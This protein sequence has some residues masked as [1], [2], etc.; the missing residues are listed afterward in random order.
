MAT[1]PGADRRGVAVSLPTELASFVTEEI[2]VRA[3][4][5]PES[6]IYG[7]S[8]TEVDSAPVLR[9]R[10]SPGG[11]PPLLLNVDGG[12]K[13]FLC[14]CPEFQKR[15]GYPERMGIRLCEHLTRL[16]TIIPAHDR[17]RIRLESGWRTLRTT[18]ELER[19]EIVT[20]AET[21]LEQGD[22]LAAINEVHYGIRG[23]RLSD[24]DVSAIL[25]GVN[26]DRIDDEDL[27]EA[28]RF[29]RVALQRGFT[30]TTRALA[31]SWLMRFTENVDH[32][33]PFIDVAPVANWLHRR[34]QAP[35]V[36]F[37]ELREKILEA[38]KRAEEK[39]RGASWWLLFRSVSRSAAKPPESCVIAWTQAIEQ[40]KLALVH[41]DR[42]N[43]AARLVTRF[44]TKVEISDKA[45][46][47]AHNA[48]VKRARERR[49]HY[50]LRLIEAHRLA[51]FLTVEESSGYSGGP[52]SIEAPKIKS[53]LE[54]FLLSA[55]GH[56]GKTIPAEDFA[57]NWPVIRRLSIVEPDIDGPVGDLARSIWP[58]KVE[59]PPPV[60]KSVRPGRI[61]VG[62][63][64]AFISRW[65]LSAPRLIANSPVVAH[66]GDRIY[67]P[68]RGG[69][70]YPDFFGVTLCR[71]PSAVGRRLFTV[72]VERRIDAESALELLKSGAQWI[73]PG[74]D[75][76]VLI[77]EP[78]ENMTPEQILAQPEML[79]GQARAL[80]ERTWFPDRAFLI[81]RIGPRIAQ[82]RA[83]GR[84]RLFDA[85][86]NDE[87]VPGRADVGFLFAPDLSIVPDARTWRAMKAVARKAQ[88]PGEWVA[89]LGTDL[90]DG[91]AALDKPSS[92]IKLE[93][94]R[95]TPLKKAIP[96]I[97]AKRKRELDGVT[98][99]F[100]G[101]FY[102]LAP[103]KKTVWGAMILS[104]LELAGRKR[105]RKQEAEELIAA[106]NDLGLDASAL[107]LFQGKK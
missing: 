74:D 89:L 61:Q 71:E 63:S 82:L 86:K 81:E 29:S 16:L 4:A 51:P 24:L 93:A 22:T 59:V 31:Y 85:L 68:S 18:T 40:M 80:S 105:L 20:Q 12:E 79:A 72:Q 100:K 78:L 48:S 50:L 41:P 65:A 55:I 33:A 43:D 99:S 66:H 5:V 92:P 19:S 70:S 87:T 60:Y 75:P 90:A 91:L 67:I 101:G 106:L 37:A 21:I 53:A 54:E 15:V 10:Y 38:L 11:E 98:M 62:A 3:Q 1:V 102:D 28:V 56:R 6:H 107:P 94:L 88:S 34:A 83:W 39:G 103:L 49:V 25:D 13:T 73:G 104:R 57:E 30:R 36:G 47:R 35:D 77:S 7:I 17:K 8:W 95:E 76:L 26:A 32:Y 69:S 97:V 27:P 58:S 64:S 9:A 46:M 2:Y 23:A 44:G 84:R 14:T 96:A 42:V 52:F 45:Y